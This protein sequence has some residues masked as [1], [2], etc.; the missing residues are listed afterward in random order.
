MKLSV[1]DLRLESEDKL[2]NFMNKGTETNRELFGLLEFVK[3]EYCSTDVLSDFFDLL[4]EHFHGIN[5]SVRAS[6]RARL[7]LP[8]ITRGSS[9]LR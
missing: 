5:P 6:P 2:Y 8:N 9:L 4:S 7:V 3:L 1:K